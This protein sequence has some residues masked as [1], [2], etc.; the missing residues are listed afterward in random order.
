MKTP[1]EIAAGIFEH[2]PISSVQR[3]CIEPQIVAALKQARRDTLRE[4]ADKARYFY[5]REP[6]DHTSFDRLAREIE[7]M[8]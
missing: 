7:G 1:Q 8:P 3:Q 5:L 6:L 4:A 2:M